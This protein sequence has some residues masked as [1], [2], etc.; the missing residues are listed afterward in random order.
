MDKVNLELEP[1]TMKEQRILHRINSFLKTIE[2]K[3][4]MVIGFAEPKEDR[5][6]INVYGVSE[7]VMSLIAEN[8][9]I[10]AIINHKK[11][12]APVKEMPPQTC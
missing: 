8:P 10:P 11:A 3:R 12:K 2:E 4:A 6:S 5:F 9:E 7:S 1:I